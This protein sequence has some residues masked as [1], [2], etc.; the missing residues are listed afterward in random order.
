MDDLITVPEIVEEYLVARKTVQRWITAGKIIP[1][2][3]LAG[4]T[5]DYLFTRAEAEKSFGEHRD[6]K[7]E[8]AKYAARR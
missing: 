7:V 1:A 8:A 3:K 6:A 5:G 2:K 4:R